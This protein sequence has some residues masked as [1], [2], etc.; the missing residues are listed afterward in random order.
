[1][2]P[3]SCL[4]DDG[5]LPQGT[6]WPGHVTLP[7]PPWHAG[8]FPAEWSRPLP[9]EGG[10]GTGCV[11]WPEAPRWLR[12]SPVLAQVSPGAAKEHWPRPDARAIVGKRVAGKMHFIQRFL[13]Q[14]R[15][16]PPTVCEYSLTS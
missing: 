14:G 1:M 3:F 16:V 7:H 15:C 4:F 2:G 11:Q 12:A 10:V 8:P 5:C 13:L 9:E 6:S